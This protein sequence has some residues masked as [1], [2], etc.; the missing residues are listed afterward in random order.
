M[1]HVFAMRARSMGFTYFRI[2][3]TISGGRQIN[4][5]AISALP[6]LVALSSQLTV[7]STKM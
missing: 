3:W 2:L 1:R 6:V 7:N 4:A 5:F